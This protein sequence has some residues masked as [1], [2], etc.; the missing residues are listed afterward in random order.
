MYP[1]L[2]QVPHWI[3]L[4]Y[5]LNTNSVKAIVEFA[6]A[7]QYRDREGRRS[8]VSKTRRGEAESGVGFR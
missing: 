1:Y 8:A 3:I 2:L 5:A 4:L 7:N 6:T